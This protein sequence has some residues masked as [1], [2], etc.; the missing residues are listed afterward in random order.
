MVGVLHSLSAEG[1]LAEIGVC[2]GGSAKIIRETIPEKELHLFDTFTGIIG[3]QI[4]DYEKEN[5]K[6]GDYSA[7]LEET[8]NNLPYEKIIYHIGDVLKTR[9]EV[10]DKKFCFI[11]IDLDIY[12]P[13]KGIL[14][15][16]YERLNKG[17]VMLISNYDIA[18]PGIKK[19][20][21]EFNKP[22]KQYSRFVNIKKGLNIII[23]HKIK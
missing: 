3:E 6:S 13:L 18:H 20:V 1:E 11:H 9:E 23:K 19:A 12:T 4:L 21:D 15:F 17:G 5:Y 2:E 10:K 14:D 22:F 8:K 7:S 16:F